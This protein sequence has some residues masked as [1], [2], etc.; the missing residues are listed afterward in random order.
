ML[1]W[2]GV[3]IHS[4]PSAAVNACGIGQVLT[5]TFAELGSMLASFCHVRTPA[6]Q[7]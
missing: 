2:L 7:T 3:T 5:T 4:A 6:T 1:A